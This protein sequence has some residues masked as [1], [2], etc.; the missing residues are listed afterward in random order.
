MNG[1]Q[2]I[3]HDYVP[4]QFY[5]RQTYDELSRA[6]MELRKRQQE[7]ETAL[8][9]LDKGLGEDQYSEIYG[10]QVAKKRDDYLKMIDSYAGELNRSGSGDFALISKIKQAKRDIDLDRSNSG[11]LGKA[12]NA[13][14]QMGKAEENA[15]ALS[16]G[17]GW[18]LNVAEENLA[19]DKAKFIE[20]EK[21]LLAADPRYTVKE[22]IPTTPPKRFT[23]EDMF[24]NVKDFVGSEADMSSIVGEYDST[25]VYD[26]VNTGDTSNEEAL[27]KIKEF[28]RSQLSDENSPYTQDLWY[29]SG[30]NK[31]KFKLL[32][33]K[34]KAQIVS[35]IEANTKK[36]H[37]EEKDRKQVSMPTSDYTNPTDSTGDEGSVGQ[38][39]M[40]TMNTEATRS[41]KVMI[42]NPG[43]GD[44][45]EQV[46]ITPGNVARSLKEME[47]QEALRPD[48]IKNTSY[49]A[50]K[51][52]VVLYKQAVDA[53]KVSNKAKIDAYVKDR[54]NSKYSDDYY[55]NEKR[56]ADAKK[57][58]KKSK[59]GSS[60]Y[61][62]YSSY[63]KAYEKHKRNLDEQFERE[64]FEKLN[65][66]PVEVVANFA[67]LNW[68]GKATNKMNEEIGKISKGGTL[69]SMLQTLI[70]EGAEGKGN[71][72]IDPDKENGEVVSKE[73]I[74]SLF[75]NISNVAIS[76]IHTATAQSAPSIK[77][78]LTRKLKEGDQKYYVNLA[79]DPSSGNV[80]GDILDFLYNESTDAASRRIIENARI[81]TDKVQV[82][83]DSDAHLSSTTKTRAGNS[84]M[85]IGKNREVLV[86]HTGSQSRYNGTLSPK[87][88]IQVA[89][90]SD[91]MFVTNYSKAGGSGNYNLYTFG[92]LISDAVTLRGHMI[93]NSKTGPIA[94][95]SELLGLAESVDIIHEEGRIN[96]HTSAYAPYS[97]DK[98]TQ[99]SLDKNFIKATNSFL[100]QVQIFKKGG[101]HP[102][103]K[104][105]NQVAQ[106]YYSAIKD[107]NLAASSKEAVFRNQKIK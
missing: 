36:A 106:E 89:L 60:E 58:L 94:F 83:P 69:G 84:N 47:F 22:F 21:A 32:L 20:R 105:M 90:T 82:I 88:E 38:K 68:E 39:K 9:D 1:I 107:M 76:G 73:G 99:A 67:K 31:E 80:S 27:K 35:L 26:V 24:K 56:I 6:P 97:K 92:N 72:V 28:F 17:Q 16:V 78:E 42:N 43:E 34:R 86:K 41:A 65:L 12:R 71:Y 29:E 61:E 101:K 55:D 100:E 75:N 48:L 10:D 103:G 52:T 93:Q 62:S 23:P 66:N 40:F 30:Q 8:S 33:N 15:R 18:A 51:E 50:Q 49:A 3:T 25:G 11:L 45:S 5:Q 87:D 53:L 44:P 95:Q 81:Y 46:E 4:T 77:I 74:K 57:V 85:Q 70:A 7:G 79:I 91:G 59:P 37:T 98:K 96:R 14:V 19:V 2:D 104:T 54:K 102:E 64:A 63:L 13:K